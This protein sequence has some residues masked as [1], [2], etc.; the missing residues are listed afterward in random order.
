MAAMD[1]EDLERVRAEGVLADGGRVS[2]RRYP[3]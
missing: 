2:M 3:R 1:V